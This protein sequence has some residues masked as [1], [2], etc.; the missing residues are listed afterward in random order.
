MLTGGHDPS[1]TVHWLDWSRLLEG[2]HQ[3]LVWTGLICDM[4]HGMNPETGGKME[5][6]SRGLIIE[7]IGK[8]LI[9]VVNSFLDIAWGGIC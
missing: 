9:Y 5:V 6:G 8:R 1:N 3:A 2:E 4:E 7:S